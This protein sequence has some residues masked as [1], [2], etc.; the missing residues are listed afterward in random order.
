MLAGLSASLA[1]LRHPTRDRITDALI[2]A[3]ELETALADA[4][5]NDARLAAEITQSLAGALIE[6]PSVSQHRAYA[7]HPCDIRVPETVQLSVPEGFAYYALHPA[8]YAEMVDSI[9][10]VAKAARVG[11][12]L[13]AAVIGIR[14]IGSTLSAVVTAA[15]ARNNIRA[16]RITVRPAGHVFDRKTYFTAAQLRWIAKARHHGAEFLVVDEGPGMSGSSFLSVGEALLSAGVERR[17]IRFLCSYEVDPHTLTAPRGAERWRGFQSHWAKTHTPAEDGL[18]GIE[19]GQ[20]RTEF[21]FPDSVSETSGAGLGNVGSWVQ[22]E[23]A[24]FLSGD[25]TRLFKFVG[26]GRFGEEVAQRA[27]ALAASG[28]GPRCLGL[29]DGYAEYEMLRGRPALRQDVSRAMIDRMADYCAMRALEFRVSGADHS[30][31]EAMA[32]HNYEQE[33]GVAPEW[34]R[35]ETRHTVICD[36]RMQPHEWIVGADGIVRKTDGD[37]HGDDHFFPGPTDIAWD[38]AGAIV[39]W[40]MDRDAQEALLDR[41]AARSE[42]DARDRIEAYVAAYAVFRIGFCRMGAAALAGSAEENR[43]SAAAESYRRFIESR[44]RQTRV[45]KSMSADHQTLDLAA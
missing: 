23:R 30:Q 22:M 29:N 24:K 43:L 6:H 37:T 20:W 44:H 16:E 32:R 12:R 14:S 17:R 7:G 8:A 26:L 13:G 15:L 4:G 21:P 18:I 10:T 19:A 38:L 41:F 31:V 36:G 11:Q 39:E 3:G 28:F 5:S 33:F 35:L 34:L 40:E 9:P 27:E 1:K 25:R 2:R 45:I 42:D